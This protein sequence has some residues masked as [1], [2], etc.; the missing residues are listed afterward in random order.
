MPVCGGI[1]MESWRS[2]M[3]QLAIESEMVL[4]TLLAISAPH[5]LV[6]SKNDPIMA[7]AVGHHFDRGLTQHGKALK[8]PGHRL[9]EQLWLPAVVIT[10]VCCILMHQVRS[11]ENHKLPLQAYNVTA[12]LALISSAQVSAR[13]KQLSLGIGQYMFQV[14]SGSILSAASQV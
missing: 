5:W 11:G 12:G 9:S 8:Q 3:P 1:R 7:I 4:S 6:H 10:H 13:S 14:K 2:T